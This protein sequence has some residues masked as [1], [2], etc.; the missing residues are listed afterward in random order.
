MQAPIWTGEEVSFSMIWELVL[1]VIGT[2]WMV[3]CLFWIIDWIE[4]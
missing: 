3:S 1:M 2:G 4:E